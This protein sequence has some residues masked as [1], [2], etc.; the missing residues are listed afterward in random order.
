MSRRI[1]TAY[2]AKSSGKAAQDVKALDSGD[3]VN[4]VVVSRKITAL[5]WGDLSGKH[6]HGAHPPAMVDVTRQKSAEVIVGVEKRARKPREDSLHRRTEH[7]KGRS[8]DELS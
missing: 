5:I 2:K 1:E 4:A 6:L 7:R 3:M 8:P